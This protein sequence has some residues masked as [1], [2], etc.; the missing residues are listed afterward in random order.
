MASACGEFTDRIGL[1]VPSIVP[2][3]GSRLNG[4]H[5]RFFGSIALLVGAV[6]FLW[7]QRDL[8]RAGFSVDSKAARAF[9]LSFFGGALFGTVAFI[10]IPY[11]H[12]QHKRRVAAESLARTRM[13]DASQPSKRRSE[14]IAEKQADDV[15]V[16]KPI[17]RK[18]VAAGQVVYY[19]HQGIGIAAIAML[20]GGF[21]LLPFLVAQGVRRAALDGPRWLFSRSR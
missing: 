18:N 15:V 6:S 7:D 21:P 5:L 2:P 8:L 20:T 16:E 11:F 14:R 3:K 9:V 4:D 13:C 12:L 1:K 10:I 17:G 19:C